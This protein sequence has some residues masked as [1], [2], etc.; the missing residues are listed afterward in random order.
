[1]NI[2][3]HKYTRPGP[4]IDPNEP[5]KKGVRRFFELLARESWDMLKLNL[6]FIACAI[7][8]IAVFLY[9]FFFGTNP[10]MFLLSLVAAFPVGGALTSFVFCMTKMLRDDPGFIWPDFKGKLFETI[11]KSVLPGIV[12]VA[13]FYSQLIILFL[14]AIGAIE[15]TVGLGVALVIANLLYGMLIPYVFM[16]IAYG[17]ITLLQIIKN[18]VFLCFANI[19]R[20]FM[21]ALMGGLFHIILVMFLPISFLFLPFILI[22][23]FALLWLLC[24]LWTWPVVDKQFSIEETL[25]KR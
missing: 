24:L 12:Y 19:R 2:F 10:F 17:D 5:R 18:S 21:G 22:Y 4:G 25:R 6:L 3:K 7:P 13:F 1:M 11:K 14:Y 9:S 8:T 16:Q 15:M 20:S 23:G